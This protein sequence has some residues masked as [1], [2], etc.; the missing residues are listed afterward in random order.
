MTPVPPRRRRSVIPVSLAL[1]GALACLPLVTSPASADS[2]G[3]RA[4]GPNLSYVVNTRA[5][6]H[7]SLARAEQAV[8]SAGGTVVAAY[9]QI[10]VIVAH[11]ADP[12]FAGR[13]RGTPGIQSAGA[14]RTAPLQPTATDDVGRPVKADPAQVARAARRAAPGADPMEP[15]QWDQRAIRADQAHARNLGSAR[16]HVGIIDTGVDDTHPDL[17]PN[18]DAKDSVSCVGG[19]ADTTAGAWRPTPNAPESYHGTHVAGIIAA[20]RNGIGIAGVAPG[21]RISS[22]RVAEPDSS[23]FYPESVVCGFVW[24]GEHHMDVTNNSYYIDPWYFNCTSD[25]DQKAIVDAVGRAAAYA[26]HRGTLNVAAAGNNN[27]DLGADSIVDYTSPDDS[28]PVGRTIDPSACPDLPAQLPGVVT[29]SATGAQ[30]VLS[31]YSNYGQGV[32]DVAAPGGDWYQVPDPPA[33]SGSVYSTLPGNSYG[34]LDGTSMASPHVAGVAALLKSTHPSASPAAIRA[35]LEAQADHIA[36]PAL[37]DPD[38]NG[39]ADAVCK[40]TK[41]D[42]GFYGHGLVDALNAVRRP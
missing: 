19:R 1:A 34:Y 29:V 12:G 27:F 11:S 4:D 30:D 23:L 13:L 25:P 6:G 35:V 37:Y 7:A 28:A 38:G 36:C 9:G 24:A 2:E 42:N 26:E 21:V 10:G 15:L 3:T 20:A 40:G 8:R 5:A 41:Q 31:S 14:T 32:V 16:V 17:A 22:I 39:E 33:T 18:F